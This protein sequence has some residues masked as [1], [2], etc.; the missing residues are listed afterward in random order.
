M[1]RITLGAGSGP[2]LR[3]LALCIGLLMGSVSAIAAEAES[4]YQSTDQWLL[5][6]YDLNG[7]ARITE[8]EVSDKK[9]RLF[10][11]MDTDND[12]GVNFDEYEQMD[13]AKR[14]ALLLSRFNKLDDDRDGR[15]SAAEY[16]SFLGMFRS[17]DSDGDGTLTAMEMGGH[18]VSRTQVTRCFLWLCVRGSL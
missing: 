11:R 16:G 14:Q 18:Q 13:I 15:V 8:K 7:D 4:D 9:R 10:T 5:A 2:V 17:I 1:T 3:P 12:G 6:K